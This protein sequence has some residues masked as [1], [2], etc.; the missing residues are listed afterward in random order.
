MEEQQ[1]I[2]EQIMVETLQIIPE[3]D[4]TPV[5][6]TTLQVERNLL[7]KLLLLLKY[8]LTIR[9]AAIVPA[10]TACPSPPCSRTS[11]RTTRCCWR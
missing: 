2:L 10:T 4:Q 3:T 7:Q 6:Q 5:E 1:A 9:S 11:R 8:I